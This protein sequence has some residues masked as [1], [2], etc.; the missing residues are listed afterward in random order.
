MGLQILQQDHTCPNCNHKWHTSTPINPEEWDGF[1]EEVQHPIIKGSAY[2]AGVGFGCATI[3]IMLM[4][5]SWFLIFVMW[6]IGYPA[7]N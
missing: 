2:G 1:K 6:L 3:L 7:G 5:A 4:L